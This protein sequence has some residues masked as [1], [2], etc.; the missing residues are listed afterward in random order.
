VSAIIFVYLRAIHPFLPS[1]LPHLYLHELQ[2]LSTDNA[3][4]GIPTATLQNLTTL[5]ITICDWK[6]SALLALFRWCTN[7]EHLTVAYSTVALNN[8]N[9]DDEDLDDLSFVLSSST[10][11]LLLPALKILSPK[12]RITSARVSYNQ[13]CKSV[14]GVLKMPNLEELD[15]GFG[16]GGEGCEGG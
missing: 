13:I 5:S 15:M 9:D 11:V 12:P 7:L 6:P 10:G 14:L 8:E 1:F 2:K 4:F 3:P 16:V